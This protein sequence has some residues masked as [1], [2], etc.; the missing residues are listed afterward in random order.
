MRN[1]ASLAVEWKSLVVSAVYITVDANFI[2]RLAAIGEGSGAAAESMAREAG[3]GS[4]WSWVGD[5][6]KRLSTAQD[7][8]SAGFLH[9][10]F[11]LRFTPEAR[12]ASRRLEELLPKGGKTPDPYFLARTLWQSAN[13]GSFF[14]SA[15]ELL[16]LWMGA[17]PPLTSG[18]ANGRKIK[19][20]I[21]RLRG[22]MAEEKDQTGPL[23]VVQRSL[24]LLFMES[25]ISGRTTALCGF[26]KHIGVII[27][28]LEVM[29]ALGRLL[30]C[31]GVYRDIDEDEWRSFLAP[32]SSG[33]EEIGLFP[34]LLHLTLGSPP[35][36]NEKL[37]NDWLLPGI[38]YA[39]DG[40]DFCKAQAL[41]KIT[42]RCALSP[43]TEEHEK[44][45][46]YD[47]FPAL[48]KAAASF[49]AVSGNLP[50]ADLQN[51]DEHNIAFV[52]T[53]RLDWGAPMQIAL[54][55]INGLIRH[56]PGKFRFYLYSPYGCPEESL[57]DYF[58]KQGVTVRWIDDG[59]CKKLPGIDPFVSKA[60]H[61]RL[62]FAARQIGIALF[63]RGDVI[64]ESLFSHIRVAPIQI[65]WAMGY[66]W[67]QF[68]NMDALLS[69]IPDA[70]FIKQREGRSWHWYRLIFAPL[71]A[72]DEKDVKA[73]RKEVVG[74]HFAFGTLCQSFKIDDEEF[75]SALA[76]ILNRAPQSVYI[77]TGTYKPHG[78]VRMMKEYGI[79]DRCIFIGWA[80]PRVCH[81]IIDVF[82]DTFPVGNGLSAGEAMSIGK[83]IVSMEKIH[84]LKQYIF[85]PAR[86][87]WFGEEQKRKFDEITGDGGY[88][89]FTDRNDYIETAVR[90]ASD[91]DFRRKAGEVSSALAF[92]FLFD[93]EASATVF[94]NAIDDIVKR[95]RSSS[96]L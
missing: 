69:C 33:M 42:A 54:L 88:F 89:S 9:R 37:Y 58:S 2:D 44:S 73:M 79:L 47:Y 20:L 6:L 53:A 85:E 18:S 32:D 38:R 81:G 5:V 27:D 31:S 70:S 26:F 49:G 36:W 8:P 74:D 66:D 13:D 51:G 16:P 64:L 94:V 43:H 82:L 63:F 10:F 67:P 11:T 68:G 40:G 50:L 41:S 71:N 57:V 52:S 86:K 72:A 96:A 90:L 1:G 45:I 30:Y 25:L 87:G 78:V 61:L 60:V 91:K 93:A 28:N 15:L 56:F 14:P 7:D 76:E 12:G 46:L 84:N 48:E 21:E 34:P 22:A 80:N 4:Y 55:M 92:A 24:G 17:A 23:A 83:P 29:T 95:K 77:W 3:Y 39:L 35:E 19:G 65:F 75:I 62:E 59:D